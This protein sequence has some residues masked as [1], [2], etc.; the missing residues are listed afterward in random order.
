VFV[1]EREMSLRRYARL[2]LTSATIVAG[3]YG[4][5]VLVTPTDE[6][7]KAVFRPDALLTKANDAGDAKKVRC[8][9][10]GKDGGE[11][12]VV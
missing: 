3:G 6:Q 2:V 12:E 9:G 11:G 7:L 8:A 1:D 5:M 10:T 4:I